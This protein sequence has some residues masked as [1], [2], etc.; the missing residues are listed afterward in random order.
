MSK[1]KT[2]TLF[3]IYT[4]FDQVENNKKF[5][6]SKH[7]TISERI[8]LTYPQNGFFQTQNRGEKRKKR[9]QKRI[10][11]KRRRDSMGLSTHQNEVC[12]HFVSDSTGETVTKVGRAAFAQFQKKNIVENLWPFVHTPRQ[13]LHILK[14]IEAQP[15]VVICT[16][17]DDLLFQ[18]LKKGCDRLGLPCISLLGPLLSFL[19]GEGWSRIAPKA[20]RQHDLD[21]AYF[22][23][24]D[25]VD[26]AL[27]HDDGHGLDTI[28]EADVILLGVSRSSK[29]P[30]CVYLSYK[31]IKAANVP[32]ILDAPLDE[33]LIQL[34]TKADR[35]LIVGLLQDPS[36]L[37][38]IRQ[39]RAE[40]LSH[41]CDDYTSTENIRQETFYAQK[42][43]KKYNIPTI[44][45]SRRSVEEIVAMVISMIGAKRMEG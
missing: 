15:G 25:A 42:L 23:R 11:L 27:N 38:N 20:G 41:D 2:K 26:F 28:H 19:E 39:K 9:V 43:F 44:S 40:H 6:L 32:L 29:T 33:R 13:I 37:R 14:K 21:S 31:G 8:L 16:L 10:V 12:V 5:L 17:V 18:E 30:C 24:I 4:V 3:E 22:R 7:K 1:E 36:L 45:V 34:L 35:P